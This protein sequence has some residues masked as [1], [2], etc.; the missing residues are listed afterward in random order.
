MTIT[1]V[2]TGTRPN[3]TIQA[4]DPY[5]TVVTVSYDTNSSLQNALQ[6][7]RQAFITAY[8]AMP[9]TCICTGTGNQ[10][11]CQCTDTNAPPNIVTMTNDITS[12]CTNCRNDVIGAF[13]DAYGMSDDNALYQLLIQY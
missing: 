5:S 12:V 8:V 2:I 11:T 10:R 1:Y 13:V 4:T 6:S 7:V 3:L 9:F